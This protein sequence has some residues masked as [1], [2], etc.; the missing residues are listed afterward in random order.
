MPSYLSEWI[1]EEEEE[2]EE[3]TIDDLKR[4]YRLETI[5]D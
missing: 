2:E 1:W 4:S 5:V 3:T